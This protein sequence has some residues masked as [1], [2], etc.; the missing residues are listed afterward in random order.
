MPS[1]GAG[2]SATIQLV[3]VAPSAGSVVN[4]A[5]V[6]ST[7]PDSNTSNNRST[8][9]LTISGSAS[10]PALSTWGLALLA[11]LLAGCSAQLIRKARV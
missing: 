3:V 1:S 7:T 10:V 5:T 6:V 11:L 9:S 8:A 2:S 4:T